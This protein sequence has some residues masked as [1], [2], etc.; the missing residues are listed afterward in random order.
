MKKFDLVNYLS[1]DWRY[2]GREERG[3]RLNPMSKN[4]ADVI[5]SPKH[6]HMIRLGDPKEDNFCLI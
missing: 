6:E 1:A 3:V 2:I 4:L 5:V